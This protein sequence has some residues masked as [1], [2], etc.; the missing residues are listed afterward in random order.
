VLISK[1][2]GS[3]FQLK[4]SSYEGRTDCL[5][6]EAG[7]GMKDVLLDEPPDSCKSRRVCFIRMSWAGAGTSSSSS[8]TGS[9]SKLSGARRLWRL[10]VARVQ[11]F[12]VKTGVYVPDKS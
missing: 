3:S 7:A 12:G 10:I 9:Q 11:G 2:A 1:G 4:S 5:A 6:G 8:G